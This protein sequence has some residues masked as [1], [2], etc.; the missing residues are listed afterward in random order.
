[1]DAIDELPAGPEFTRRT[2]SVRGNLVDENGNHV[3]E[4]V[5]FYTRDPVACVKELF[6]NPA[7]KNHTVYKPRRV[8]RKRGRKMVREYNEMWTGRWWWK[9]QVRLALGPTS[10][11]YLMSFQ[12]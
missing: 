1:M 5:E 9:M 12:C 11:R 3:V 2:I 4:E 6:E 10:M 8:F 7:L